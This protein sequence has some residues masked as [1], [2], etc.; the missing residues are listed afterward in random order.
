MS[1]T[2]TCPS[3]GAELPSDAPKGFC[4]RCLYRLGFDEGAQSRLP[5]EPAVEDSSPATRHSSLSRSFGDYELLQE[6]GHGGMGVVYRARQKS[7]DRMV[8]LKMLLFGPHAPPESVKRFRAEAVATAA[9]Q[10]P[11]IVAIHEV[12]F[13]EGQHFIGMDYVEGQSLSAL[14]RGSPLPA[15]RAAG[16]VKTMAEA[17]HYAHEHG[18]LHRD[19][20]PA[21]VLIDAN[22]QPRITDFGL[23]KRLEGD[24]E[25]TVTGQVL[26]SPNYMPPEQAT[27]KR[28]TVSRRT[29]VYALGA[30]LYHALT[31]R[32]PFVGE[33]MAETVQQMLNVE[34][35]S[36]RVL[37][38]SV[39]ADV[40]TVCLKCLEKEPGKR[41][42]TA[43]M[44]AEELDR[45]LEGKPVLA[46]PVGRLAKAWRWC[47][48]NPAL[49]SLIAALVVVIIGG[50]VGVLGQLRRA[51]LAELTALRTA[52]VAD[53]NL[54]HHALAM[55]N[56]GRARAL[57]GKYH[58]TRDPKSEIDLRGWEWRYLWPRCQSDA[59]FTLCQHS[60]TIGA[61]AFAGDGRLLAV[62]DQPGNIML[63]DLATRQ[64]IAHW[65][66][67]AHN[68][69]AL[70]VSPDGN[71]LAAGSYAT[72]GT[73]IV[74]LRDVTTRQRVGELPQA[75]A[76]SLAFSPDGKTLATDAFDRTVRV[77]NLASQK[78]IASFTVSPD[79]G[80]HKGVVA[81][82]PDG[83]TLA[84]GETD[85]RIRLIA[86]VSNTERASFRAHPEGEG[87]TALAFS[88]DSQFVASASGYSDSTI[89]LWEVATGRSAGL[90]L[91]HA[92]WVI[93][94]AL[95]PDG[96]T[97]ASASADQTIRLWDLDRRRCSA[98]LR[99]HSSEVWALAFSPDGLS[100]ASGGKDGS[101]CFWDPRAKPKDTWALTLPPP[102][103]WL[104]FS[105]DGRTFNTLNLDGS[106]SLW[107]AATAQETATFTDLGTN[108]FSLAISPDGNRLVAGTTTGRLAVWDRAAQ[109]ELTNF[110]GHAAAIKNL[111]FCSEGRLLVSVATDRTVKVWDVPSWR[112][113][114]VCR[115][116]PQSWVF[117]PVF[118][119]SADGRLAAIGD[120]YMVNLWDL[121]TGKKAPGLTGRFGWLDGLAFSPDGR[122]L[123]IGSSDG[124]ARLFELATRR[125]VA[126]LRG[127][128]TGVHSVAF[129]PDGRRLA[130]GSDLKEA[131]K[132]WD[133]TTLQEVATL[134]GQGTY[135][136]FTTFSPDGNTL[137]GVNLQG[138]AHFWRA[139]SF[140]QI[141]AIEQGKL[142]KR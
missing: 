62:R 9:L 127:H 43:Q 97:L 2:G 8:A 132:L 15:R 124:S 3:C 40:E 130:T 65:S 106:I 33:G 99:G 72:N 39:P 134:E 12:G 19:L 111:Q 113:K 47:R 107:D 71:L 6:I 5:A 131:V 85:G 32:P 73:P 84:I 21:N 67:E 82:S 45:F 22:D 129:S 92:A 58:P 80:E 66:K 29:D 25:L 17:I 63:W 137:V 49:A 7:L 23:A 69:R 10:H 16:Y 114:T 54:A 27:G 26:G 95:A 34:P 70:A 104:V 109:R 78:V 119:A 64:E 41:Y 74:E 77:W 11:N 88:A 116:D 135:F 79:S 44:L 14:I 101:I 18:I 60:N 120:A 125:E 121:A 59:L 98:T 102:I 115:L 128:L 36:P 56:L 112:E 31:G 89:R 75:G 20:K 140:T 103:R 48:R 57:L 133:M 50:F 100:L 1:D 141:T 76:L 42:A 37:N 123:A 28:G 81:F 142:T 61:L 53:M 136:Q 96:R 35:V 126:D 83:G 138:T 91:G 105:P 110:M 55:N 93:A 86:V 117:W 38:P 68:H 4:P 90:F 108:N 118:E 24:S 52:Y 87:I 51:K 122:L 94:L 46:R 13:C 30:I 139:P